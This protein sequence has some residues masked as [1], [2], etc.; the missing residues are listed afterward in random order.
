[1]KTDTRIFFIRNCLYPQIAEKLRNCSTAKMQLKKKF[2][3]IKEI[4]DIFLF[5]CTCFHVSCKGFNKHCFE[6][7]RRA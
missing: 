1:M 3:L 6:M 4:L 2:V 7:F 5:C